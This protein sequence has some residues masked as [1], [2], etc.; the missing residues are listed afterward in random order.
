MK[1]YFSFLF[2]MLFLIGCTGNDT[3][4]DTDI[5]VPVSVE[6]VKYKSIEQFIETTGTVMPVKEAVLSSEIGGKYSLQ[7]NPGT[8]RNYS[9]GDL[10]KKGEVIIKIE[11]EEFANE[12][13]IDLKKH[14]LD[15]ALSE[16]EKQKSIYD[17][18]GV[19]LR[20]LNTSETDYLNAK[21]TYE[22]A[23]IQLEK[24]K[25]KSP[26]DG[27]IVDIPYYTENV[28]ISTGRQVL[29]VMNYSELYMEINLPEKL[30]DKINVKQS[31]RIMNYTIEDDTLKGTISQISPAIDTQTR[32]FE[33]TLKIENNERLLRPGMFAKAELII[34]KKDSVLVIPKDII[35]SKQRGKTVFVVAKGAAREAV[36]TTG[37]ENPTHVEVVKGL[38]LN[39]RIVT[40][41]FETLR[42]RSKVKIIK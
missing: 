41:G 1:K 22:N 19:T 28:K 21:Y 42:N 36:I 14:S 11:D 35:L 27:V 38:K 12:I 24:T 17:K 6:D 20:E 29:K 10:V 23:V 26:F 25:V 32:T 31:A 8:K 13:R 7:I 37:L 2:L 5:S 9:L 3:D 33:A 34:A 4:F 39:E 30:L 15:N 18:G 16:Y 40:K